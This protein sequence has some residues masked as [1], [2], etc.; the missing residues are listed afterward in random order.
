MLGFHRRRA[1]RRRQSQAGV[2]KVVQV[3]VRATDGGACTLP[4]DLEHVPRER[5]A[6]DTGKDERVSVRASKTTQVLT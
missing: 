6:G 2:S 1:C 5:Y 4:G 3:E